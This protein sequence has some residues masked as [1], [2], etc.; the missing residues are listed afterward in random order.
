MDGSTGHRTVRN[1]R[2]PRRNESATVAGLMR[3]RWHSAIGISFVLSCAFGCTAELQDELLEMSARADAAPQVADIEGDDAPTVPSGPPAASGI[4]SLPGDRLDA[5]SVSRDAATT[6]DAGTALEDD[7]AS[8]GT[9]QDAGARDDVSD[10]TAPLPMPQG[11]ADAGDGA[12]SVAALGLLGSEPV[13]G[14]TDVDVDITLVLSFDRD[15]R[16]GDGQIVL[17]EVADALRVEAIPAMDPRVHFYHGSP[18]AG[19]WRVTVDWD[20]PLR[21]DT[22][23]AVVVEPNAIF[24]IDASTF[25][26]LSEPSAL[27][28]TTDAPTPVELVNTSPLPDATDVARDADVVITFSDEIVAGAVGEIA[29]LDLELDQIVAHESVA[30]NPRVQISGTTLT[31]NPS[32]DLDYATTYCCYSTQERCAA[33]AAP[34]LQGS[35]KVMRSR[36]R[37]SWPLC[38]RS[39]AALLLPAPPTSTRKQTWCSVSIRKCSRPRARSRCSPVA[40]ACSSKRSR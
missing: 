29:L 28:F 13:S 2:V 35:A 22:E 12:A 11:S 27:T 32:E 4:G 24:G 30:T 36:S 21:H 17:L 7:G 26:T 37:R 25:T 39:R 5:G 6:I 10:P 19:P 1:R 18:G 38:R 9:L 15:V 14:A 23:Y 20:E 31:F 40:A 3:G 8:V 33:R 34:R 16:A